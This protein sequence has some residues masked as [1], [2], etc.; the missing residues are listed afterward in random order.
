MMY[1]HKR[2]AAKREEIEKLRSNFEDYKRR[3]AK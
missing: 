3:M 2:T 1:G